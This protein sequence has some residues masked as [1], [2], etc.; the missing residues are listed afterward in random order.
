VTSAN[1]EL[2]RSL[3]VAWG[4]GDWSSVDWADPDIEFVGADAL[5]RRSTKGLAGLAEAWRDFLDAWEE[6]RVEPEEFRELDDER[7]LVFIKLSGRGRT[8]GLDVGQMR[9]EGANLFHLKAGKVTR[10]ALYFDRE[11]ALADAGLAAES[12]SPSS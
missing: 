12:D 3:Y 6:W 7:V 9:G 2:V 4:R 11:L 10:L 8:S 1:L 5:T